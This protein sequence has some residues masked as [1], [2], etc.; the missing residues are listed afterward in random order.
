[1]DSITNTT[2]I[3]TNGVSAGSSITIGTKGS[4]ITLVG[5]QTAQ[6]TVRSTMF[7]SNL[8]ELRGEAS[9]SW[10]AIGIT[11]E[12]CLTGDGPSTYGAVSKKCARIGLF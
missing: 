3:Y 5:N 12:A 4:S 6:G 11:T 9:P 8:V 7:V 2:T 1:M 10:T